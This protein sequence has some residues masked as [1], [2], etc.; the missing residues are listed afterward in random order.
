MR[1][2]G[3]VSAENMVC[4]KNLFFIDHVCFW[5]W[6]FCMIHDLSKKKIIIIWLW[7]IA[8]KYVLNANT[9]TASP[10]IVQTSHQCG[11]I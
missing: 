4:I 7:K 11:F 2:G 1:L 6:F 3:C 8:N 5:L 9:N 10:C